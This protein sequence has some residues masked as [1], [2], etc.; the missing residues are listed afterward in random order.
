MVAHLSFLVVCFLSPFSP[1]P[2]SCACCCLCMRLCMRL[3]LCL[4]LRLRLRLRLRMPLCGF[5]MCSW[6]CIFLSFS[7]LSFFA[8]GSIFSLL[9]SL[10]NEII[11]KIIKY[12][13]PRDVIVMVCTCATLRELIYKDEFL[14]RDLYLV[15]WG[16]FPLP[17][18]K[19]LETSSW[20]QLYFRTVCVVRVVMDLLCFRRHPLLIVAVAVVSLVIV[21]SSWW[22]VLFCCC[23][24]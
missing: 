6:I 19:I 4:C 21:R 23:C 15:K 13:S 8:D 18:K 14:W 1:S 20:R 12:S 16:A 22:L 5:F 3:R 10:P 24:C 17:R 2:C 11:L 9:L 7:L